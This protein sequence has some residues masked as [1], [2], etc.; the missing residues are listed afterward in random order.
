MGAA[1]SVSAPAMAAQG[2]VHLLG[3]TG[4]TFV[5]HLGGS[6]FMKTIEAIHDEG[7]VV[8]KVYAK[9]DATPLRPHQERLSEIKR[10]LPLDECPNVMPFQ[11]TVETDKAAYLF[12]QHFACNLRDRLVTRPFLL[13]LE[14]RWIAFQLLSALEQMH[15]RGV[16]HGD[17]KPENVLLTTW[18][19]V[20]L[21]DAAPYKPALLPEDP[22]S[23]FSFFFDAAGSR[24][25]CLAPERFLPAPHAPASP[26][27]SSPSP[28]PSP[29]PS[30]APAASAGAAALTPAMD[31]F[32]AGCALAELLL[33][34][35]PLFDL[36]ALLRYRRGE[37]PGP[38][39]ALAR[40]PDAPLRALVAHMTQRDPAARLPAAAYLLPGAVE[41]AGGAFPPCFPR[42]HA[43][44]AG[45]RPWTRTRAWRP[46]PAPCRTSSRWRGRRVAPAAA[47]APAALLARRPR[48]RAGR[49]RGGGR[50][51]E[52]AAGRPAAAAG[53][54]LARPLH[55]LPRP[56]ARPVVPEPRGGPA[57]FAPRVP[58]TPP[59]PGNGSLLL[60][61]PGA[62]EPG[63]GP[64]RG[65]P[66]AI[67]AGALCA[68]FRSLRL[69]ESKLRALDLM[70]QISP[71]V[72]DEVRLQRLVPFAATA[73]TDAAPRVR[74]AAL[75]TLT[76]L[77]G[78]VGAVPEG[79]GPLFAEY[80]LPAL[81][82]LAADPDELVRVEYA[83]RLADLA[84]TARRFLDTSLLAR[85]RAAAA[86]AGAM[87]RAPSLAPLASP[88]G[89]PPPRTSLPAAAP[90]S[91]A[92]AGPAPAP[93]PLSYDSELHG[94]QE[95]FSR[96]VMDMM[97]RDA[98]SAVRTVLLA[99]MD[100]L[101]VMLGRERAANVALPLLISTLNDRDPQLRRGFFRA[102]QGMACFLG[103]AA[104]HE[105]LLPCILQAFQ[106]AE[107]GLLAAALAAL[108]ALCRL[109]LV[110]P[111][112]LCTE[113]A[114]RAA[115]LLL[116]PGLTVRREAARLLA[117]AAARLGPADA[118]CGLLPVLR[119]VLAREPPRLE[120]PEAILA[121]LPP[122]VLL[123]PFCPPL[124]LLLAPH[125]SSA[126]V[127]R[128]AFAR[129]VAAAAAAAS[130][131]PA[132]Q[133]RPS[134]S[135]AGATP[136]GFSPALASLRS[137]DP[138]DRS[139]S[140]P[141]SAPIAMP[142]RPGPA[143]R[144]P[145]SSRPLV[146][147]PPILHPAAPPPPLP[148]DEERGSSPETSDPPRAPAAS[149]P[150]GPAP[151]SG[152]DGPAPRPA[153]PAPSDE[154]AAAASPSGRGLPTEEAGTLCRPAP[155]RAAPT[156][157]LPQEKLRRLAPYIRAAA[158][159][160]CTCACAAPARASGWGRAGRGD[161]GSGD[162]RP[163]VYGAPLRAGEAAL[164]RGRHAGIVAQA[165]RP[166]AFAEGEAGAGPGGAP[167][168]PP[169][170][171]RRPRARRPRSAASPRRR[172]R[173]PR[174]G[175]SRPRAPPPVAR[176][177][178]PVR[179]SR[180]RPAGA[181]SPALVPAPGRDDWA[182]DWRPRGVLALHLPAHD[183]AVNRG[184]GLGGRARA[185]AFF[186]RGRGLAAGADAGSIALFDL[187]AGARP[188][189]ARRA[190]LPCA[191]AGAGANP[192]TVL[193]LLDPY[194]A[195][196]L[197]L[198]ASQRS[199]AAVAMDLRARPERPAWSL[200]VAP[201]D[202]FLTAALADVS[203]RW[204]LG[205]THRGA[206]LLWDLRFAVPVRSW[207][208]PARSRIHSLLLYPSSSW[209]PAARDGAA[210]ARGGAP[211]VCV[212]AGRNEVSV[213]P[214][215]AG[216]AVRVF[217][218]SCPA[219]PLGA[220]EPPSP[221]PSADPSAGADGVAGAD[222]N[223][224][225]EELGSAGALRAEP[226][227]RAQLCAPDGWSGLVTAGS[228][229]RVRWWDLAG[230]DSYVIC[231]PPAA[232]AAA[233]AGPERF[234]YVHETVNGVAYCREVAPPTPAAAAPPSASQPERSARVPAAPAHHGDAVL[235]VRFA[236]SPSRVLLSASRDGAIKVWK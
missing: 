21:A 7:H 94:L 40:I 213:Y 26:S 104:L 182:R 169:P 96:L 1:T 92:G 139:P 217:Q 20:V 72:E 74:A 11:R 100:R 42:L 149:G 176:G 147:S 101:C 108:A 12:R 28:S 203:G 197:L 129:A 22:P 68:A 46:S 49:P 38:G 158:A 196:A 83:A 130:A 5:D 195:Q 133:R 146:G 219:R 171:P 126:Q 224:A 187:E 105:F 142:L 173:S 82:S 179:S 234:S 31:V 73:L 10:L 4:L 177:P 39:P 208:H 32:G 164:V 170:A 6:R 127:S 67:L 198:A 69:P 86:A 78:A 23:D 216:E 140:L 218:A 184:G 109:E 138:A 190:A 15:G 183:A 181:P 193:E 167:P 76:A 214:L 134:E 62:G 27:P 215:D 156:E 200:P 199:G 154:A 159:A 122:P 144:G 163:R 30:T 85:Q 17:V 135:A 19:W 25:C 103:P 143:P 121:S 212:A 110:R 48:R 35:A 229:G 58:A 99:E 13:P 111:A 29:S 9:R 152:S 60:P 52:P 235:D 70:L 206:L 150:S 24:R 123:F 153:G 97:S 188:A 209:G 54:R 191:G 185:V 3:M 189:R 161:G 175:P 118:F 33:D 180:R 14:K 55:A 145:A 18:D 113:V 221:S 192:V 210:G 222:L 75:R 174:S 61:Q 90:E 66:A 227:I 125:A 157:G 114:P 95:A 165:A 84:D 51:A 230:T 37:G 236:A 186:E 65:T 128:E 205:G 225:I 207:R 160:L 211:R 141:A 45:L 132:E 2:D 131:S 117:T 204:L 80:V 155:P 228:D 112:P 53:A 119:P 124:Y 102:A 8:V 136:A 137:L 89:S 71:A 220:P 77:L 162:G 34:G 88:A 226:S 81:S 56:R 115:P 120:S 16:C 201:S 151:P 106:D 98:P 194:G 178:L 202:G 223:G 231:G 50:R 116:H 36:G 64:A 233:G 93:P 41:G 63:P 166:A 47:A 107:E 43:F 172:P 91:P 87:A 79:E 168:R 57:A 44:L 232:G 59:R 148:P